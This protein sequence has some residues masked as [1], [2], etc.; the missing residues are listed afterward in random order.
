MRRITCKYASI[1]SVWSSYSSGLKSGRFCKSLSVERAFTK[2]F[3][4]SLPIAVCAS[5]T[6]MAYF[7]CVSRFKSFRANANFCTVEIMILF[8]SLSAVAKFFEFLRMSLTVPA[9]VWKFTTSSAIF[10]FSTMRSVTIIML[11]K[12]GVWSALVILAS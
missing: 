11:S 12:I 3:A 4:L 6:I 1:A 2:S 5:S 7:R 10:L 9:T 8:P